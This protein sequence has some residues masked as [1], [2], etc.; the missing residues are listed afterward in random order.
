ME[1]ELSPEELW[2]CRVQ[3][4]TIQ[5]ACLHKHVEERPFSID[6]KT[7]K[8]VHGIMRRCADCGMAEPPVVGG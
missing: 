8:R 7:G 5:N 1:R 2:R 6:D 3:L 4:A